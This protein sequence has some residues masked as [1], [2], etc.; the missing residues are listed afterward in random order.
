[1][2]RILPLINFN[3]KIWRE[4]LSYDT[5]NNEFEK[6]ENTDLVE[7]INNKK[8]QIKK[9]IEI[10]NNELGH[11]LSIDIIKYYILRYI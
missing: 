1:L 6:I 2:T 8:A 10:V 7:L 3:K 5:N 9:T 11:F 4:L